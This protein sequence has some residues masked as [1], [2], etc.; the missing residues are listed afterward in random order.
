MDRDSVH[1]Q[2]ASV[3]IKHAS[4]AVQGCGCDDSL[5]HLLNYVWPN[6]FEI[7]PHMISAVLEATESTSATLG[8]SYRMQAAGRDPA[9]SAG[10]GVHFLTG[11]AEGRGLGW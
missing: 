11:F 4:L 10:V 2:M 5:V 9:L 7:G 3:C 8:G 1:R 6:L